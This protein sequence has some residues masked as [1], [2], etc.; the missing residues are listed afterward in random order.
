M[1]EEA[2][3]EHPGEVDIFFTVLPSTLF[4]T[5]KSTIYDWNLR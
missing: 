3:L 4:S 1:T 2:L 5:S